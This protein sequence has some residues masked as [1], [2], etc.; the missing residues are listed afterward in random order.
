[1]LDLLADQHSADGA[2]GLVADAMRDRATT[3]DR[4]RAALEL[5]P[6]TRWRMVV[7]DALP[8]L[9]AGAQSPLEIRD[10]RLR[11]RRGLPMGTRQSRRL[12]DG[13]EHLDVLI[14]EWRLHVELDGRL[15][16][17]R[18][19]EVWRDMR[20]DNRVSGCSCDICATAGPTWA[21][22]AATWR[23]SRR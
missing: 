19:R 11:R 7:I 5:R 4:L 9:R 16:H 22:V 8:D 14:E 18:A 2:L 17:D 3:P 15:G 20:R 10:A 23:S 13:T 6:A 21:I 1:V 12:G